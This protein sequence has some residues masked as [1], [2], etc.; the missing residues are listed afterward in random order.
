MITTA[1]RYIFRL[2][3]LLAA[4][5]LA[6][7]ATIASSQ[8]HAATVTNDTRANAIEIAELPHHSTHDTTTATSEPTDPRNCDGQPTRT[9]WFSYKAT[10]TGNLVASTAGSNYATVIEVLEKAGASLT[11]IACDVDTTADRQGAITGFNVVEGHTYVFSVG[12]PG[13][14]SGAPPTLYSLDFSLRVQPDVHVRLDG[15]AWVSTVNDTVTITGSAECSEK[16]T[17]SLPLSLRQAATSSESSAYG[18]STSFIDCTTNRQLFSVRVPKS[19]TPDFRRGATELTGYAEVRDAGVR[20][21]VSRSVNIIPCTLIGTVGHDRISG[22]TSADRI[23]TLHGNDT[24]SARGGSD[25][26]YAGAGNDFVSMGAGSGR[27]YGDAGN[28]NITG[29]N[30]ADVVYGGSGADIIKL[31]RGR[32]TAYGQSA[33]DRIYGSD[34]ADFLSG[35]GGAD[36]LSGGAASDRCSGGAGRDSFAACEVRRQ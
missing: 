14:S 31:G 33:G 9:V 1:H 4:T 22:T 3:A 17:V 10:G 34:H 13:W 23:C 8:A 29:G 12:A 5:A 27:A 18:S 16:V 6:A 30:G 19:S 36:H 26:V 11:P 21:R 32:D 25:V 7:V 2:L 15:P 20:E 28:D 24:I 35:G